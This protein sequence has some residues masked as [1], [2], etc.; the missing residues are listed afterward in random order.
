[1]WFDLNKSNWLCNVWYWFRITYFI[2]CLS[3]SSSGKHDHSKPDKESHTK[4]VIKITTTTLFIHYK[5]W[6]LIEWY[7]PTNSE[8]NFNKYIVNVSNV[9]NSLGVY[10]EKVTVIWAMNKGSPNLSCIYLVI[11]ITTNWCLCQLVIY[12]YNG[13][14]AI[15][16]VTVLYFITL[17]KA[18]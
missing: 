8:S 10:M 12:Y 9:H 6:K 3:L 7:P 4:T 13:I 15:L 5:Q 14:H 11:I 17:R 16:S 1:M 18:M 2:K